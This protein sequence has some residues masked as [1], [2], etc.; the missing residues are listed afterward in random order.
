MGIIA[1]NNYYNSFNINIRINT[2]K[3]EFYKNNNKSYLRKAIKSSLL[4]DDWIK[5]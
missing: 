1:Y 4:N 2:I 3:Y 5:S